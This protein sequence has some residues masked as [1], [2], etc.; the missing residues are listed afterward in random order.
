MKRLRYWSTFAYI[1]LFPL[2]TE[3]VRGQSPPTRSKG[4]DKSEEKWLLDRSLV[5][6]PQSAPVPALKYRLFPFWP[7]RKEGNAVPMYLRFAHERSDATKRLLQENTD[8]WNALPLD[9]LPLAE[10]G[11]YVESWRYNLKQL[12]LGARRKSADWSYA[13]RKSVV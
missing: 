3:A 1:V 12:E 10:A 5:V 8:K 6:S 9:E 7:D 13:N 2:M 4:V 11:K